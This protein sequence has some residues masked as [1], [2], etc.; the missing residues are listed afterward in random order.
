MSVLCLACFPPE[1]MQET[2]NVHMHHHVQHAFLSQ[3]VADRNPL[4]PDIMRIEERIYKAESIALSL[5]SK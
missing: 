3:G 4:P 2:W 1:L 5:T